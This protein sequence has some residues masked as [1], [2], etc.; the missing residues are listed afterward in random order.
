MS[1]SHIVFHELYLL[2]LL[3]AHANSSCKLP[4]QAHMQC[5]HCHERNLLYIIIYVHVCMYMYTM[6]PCLNYISYIHHACI[7]LQVH[8]HDMVFMQDKQYIC[9]SIYT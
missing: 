7:I 8:V 1:A 4:L 5:R 3:L 6:L 2:A 9:S